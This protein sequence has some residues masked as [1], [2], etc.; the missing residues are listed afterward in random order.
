MSPAIAALAIDPDGLRMAVAR[1]QRISVCDLS[2]GEIIYDI[3][4]DFWSTGFL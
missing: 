3:V 2:K 1:W 4:D